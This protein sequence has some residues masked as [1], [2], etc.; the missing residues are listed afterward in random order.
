[1]PNL[2]TT[3]YSR[4]L[5]SKGSQRGTSC[6]TLLPKQSEG[7]REQ[8]CER[9]ELQMRVRGQIERLSRT[10]ALR[11]GGDINHQGKPPDDR[12]G[13]GRRCCR[14]PYR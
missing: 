6:A 2:L 9:S 13:R 14:G 12:Y 5:R 4:P 1:M 11:W 3:I 10:L 7:E 8:L